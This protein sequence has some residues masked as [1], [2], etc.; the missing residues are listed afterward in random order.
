MV[1][2]VEAPLV[3][4]L[5]MEMRPTG[6]MREPA[7]VTMPGNKMIAERIGAMIVEVTHAVEEA[8]KSKPPVRNSPFTSYVCKSHML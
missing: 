7:V 2:R 8:G 3:V 6:V 1:I 5:N 4:D